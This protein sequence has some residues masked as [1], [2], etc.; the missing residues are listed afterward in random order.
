MRYFHFFSST[1]KENTSRFFS[2]QILN[3]TIRFETI[4]YSVIQHNLLNLAAK[5]E[6]IKMSPLVK[7][8]SVFFGLL[9]R[10][11]I[12]KPSKHLDANVKESHLR[13]LQLIK[14]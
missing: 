10:S 3:V 1:V 12:S 4:I 13:C 14:A 2:R 11:Q 6:V 7:Y 8:T 9:R 5:V